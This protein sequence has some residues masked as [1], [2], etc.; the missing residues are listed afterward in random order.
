MSSSHEPPP[1]PPSGFDLPSRLS[2][3]A[4][5]AYNLWWTWHGE[6]GRIFRLIDP[7]LWE[8]S[9]HNPVRFLRTV[10][11]RRLSQAWHNREFMDLYHRVIRAFDAYLQEQD[12]W[13]ARHHPDRLNQPIAYFSTEFGLHET[14]PIY[15]GGLG[16]LSEDHLKEGDNICFRIGNVRPTDLDSVRRF[17]VEKNL[18]RGGRDMQCVVCGKTGPVD[19]V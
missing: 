1:A 7:E 8:Q 3:L 15:A 4:D 12:T 14:L 19:R 2:R 13:Y 6:T 11:R 16:V 5:L 9:E 10:P 18:P 17:W